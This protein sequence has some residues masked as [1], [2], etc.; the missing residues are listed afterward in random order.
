MFS[1]VKFASM[2]LGACASVGSIVVTPTLGAEL[3]SPE[4][5]PRQLRVLDSQEV[6]LGARSIIYNRVETPVLTP[7]PAPAQKSTGP[8][9]EY[10]PTAA[11]SEETRRWEAMNHVSLALS[12][13][14][15]DEAATLVRWLRPD[16]EYV[17]WSSIDFNHLRGLVS[18]ESGNVY[19]TIWMGIG[20][21]T[22]DDVVRWNAE[23]EKDEELRSQYPDLRYPVPPAHIAKPTGAYSTYEFV[24]SPQTG[25]DPQVKASIDA[26]HVYHAANKD[27]LAREFAESEVARVAHEQWLK[28]N[29]PQPKDTVIQFFP[30]QSDHSPT[31]ARTLESAR[32]SARKQ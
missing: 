19:Y 5:E 9:A 29:P 27:K 17:F 6:Y 15:Y 28:D 4:R 18:F 31:E 10:A 11:E 12:C 14:V 26:L 24:D 8:V 2:F 23:V 16:G 25:I 3:A 1:A 30:I 21:E 32:S 20:N 13:T 22:T 7:Q